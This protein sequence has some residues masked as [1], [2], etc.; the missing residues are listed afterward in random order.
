MARPPSSPAFHRSPFV[1]AVAAWALPGLGYALLGQVAR[2]VTVGA[3]VIGLFVFGLLI[4]GVRALEVPGVERAEARWERERSEQDLRSSRKS[5]PRQ[6]AV[7]DDVRNKPWSVV[8][9]LTGPVGLAGMAGSVWA[10]QP[11]PSLKDGEPPRAR[12]VESHARVNEL[13]ILYT[14]VAGML[15][16]LAI[17][18]SAHRAGRMLEAE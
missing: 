9:V 7:L 2:G 16:L 15:N 1:V 12:G 17:I 13:A 5:F 10:S 4:G 11:D 6:P 3:T 14:A 18:D 8:Q